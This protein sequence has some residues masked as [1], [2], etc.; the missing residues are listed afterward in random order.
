MHD[1][2]QDQP[3]EVTSQAV[4]RELRTSIRQLRDSGLH[5]AAAWAAEQL[6]G[7]RVDDPLND[8]AAA[9]G[10]SEQEPFV[11]CDDTDNMLLARRLVDGKV[12]F[13]TLQPAKPLRR[14][15]RFPS[16][17]E[18]RGAQRQIYEKCN[19]VGV[20]GVPSRPQHL[21][22]ASQMPAENCDQAMSS[23]K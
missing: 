1:G 10:L 15:Y 12:Y 22:A 13:V 19:G 16:H 2:R 9:A 18:L 7:L 5:R 20:S 8:S 6:V 21:E 11:N 4:R 3:Y 14:S 23:R 17:V